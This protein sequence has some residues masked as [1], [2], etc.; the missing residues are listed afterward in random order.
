MKTNINH[1]GTFEKLF[2]LSTG[3][4]HREGKRQQ[5]TCVPFQCSFH[6][7]PHSFIPGLKPSFSANIPTAAFLFFFRTDYT[8]SPLF[9]V[10]S[11][12]I[13]FLLFSFSV[14][15]VLVVGSVRRWSSLMSAFERTLKSHLVSYRIVSFAASILSDEL[16]WPATSRPS[17][18]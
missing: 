5:N 17:Y 10:T 6:T 1:G 8:D 15:H 9:T 11:E 7:T 12:H 3:S 18:S 14:L 13:L 4:T 16:K 2:K